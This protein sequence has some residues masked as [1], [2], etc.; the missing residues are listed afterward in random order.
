VADDVFELA[1]LLGERRLGE[2]ESL[3][4]ASEVEFFGDGDEVSE[5]AEF[6]L[7]IHIS[8]IIIAMNKILDIWTGET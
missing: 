5:M 4:G 2:V 8:K 6:N 1:D 3:G 7:A